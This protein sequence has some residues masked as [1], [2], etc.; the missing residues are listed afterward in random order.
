[1]QLFLFIRTFRS[2]SYSYFK[3]LKDRQ[4]LSV[5][6]VAIDVAGVVVAVDADVVD[7]VVVV[8][9]VDVVDSVLESQL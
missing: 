9:A 1:M 2:Y 7:V 4:R 6:V 5:I 8:V 3:A